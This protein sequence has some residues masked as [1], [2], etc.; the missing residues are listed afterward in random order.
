MVLPRFRNLTKQI[1]VTRPLQ[2][3]LSRY[4]TKALIP[5]LIGVVDYRFYDFQSLRDVVIAPL[6]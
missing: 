5:D 2:M 4:R 6:V 1:L 3:N